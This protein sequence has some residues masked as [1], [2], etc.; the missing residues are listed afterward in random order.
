MLLHECGHHSLFLRTLFA[1]H[2]QNPRDPASHPLRPDPR[3]VEGALHAAFALARITVGLRRL[4]RRFGDDGSIGGRLRR[5]VDK[6]DATL[7]TLDEVAVWTPIGMRLFED[8]ERV[9]ASGHD[10]VTTGGLT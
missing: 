2:L 7:V 4:R 5:N 1:R 3:P 9:A 8:L 10:S 6:L